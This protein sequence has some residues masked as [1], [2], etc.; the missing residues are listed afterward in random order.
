MKTT[1][2]LSD[3]ILREAKR[4]AARDHTTVRALVEEGLRLVLARRRPGKAFKLRKAAFRGDG[5]QAGV[6]LGDW[7]TIRDLIYAGRG[8]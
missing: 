1:V 5:L 4:A 3:S 6:S 7:D 8:A 2:E